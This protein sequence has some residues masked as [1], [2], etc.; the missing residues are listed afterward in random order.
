M[1]KLT[2]YSLNLCQSHVLIFRIN[3][4]HLY[5]LNWKTEQLYTICLCTKSIQTW[6]LFISHIGLR[7]LI[8]K[9]LSAFY[10]GHICADVCTSHLPLYSVFEQQKYIQVVIIYNIKFIQFISAIQI[11]LGNRGLLYQSLIHV[12][13]IWVSAWLL[14]RSFN[15][16]IIF[17]SE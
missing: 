10:V 14:C 6:C 5:H 12:V 1:C 11:I 7:I 13:R 8:C 3:K 9:Y 15:G 17:L 4:H 2:V 16:H